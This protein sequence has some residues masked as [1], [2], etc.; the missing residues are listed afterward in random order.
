MK[1]CKFLFVLILLFEFV[2]YPILLVIHWWKVYHFTEGKGRTRNKF[3]V[4]RKV[5]VCVHEWGGYSPVR[6][7]TIKK[8]MT[9]TCGL[10]S[11]IDRFSDST[12]FDLWITMSDIEKWKY[13]YLLEKLKVYSVSNVGMDFSGYN[14][15]YQNNKEKLDSYVILTNSSVNSYNEEFIA[16]Y[17][18]YMENNLDVGALEISYCTKMYQTLVRPNF[19]PHIQSFFILTT[20]CV[21]KEIVNLNHGHF[22]GDGV[23]DKLLL[24]RRGEIKFSQL[25]LKAGY[26]LAVVDPMTKKPFKFTSFTNWIWCKGDVRQY[27]TQPN[28]I[29]SIT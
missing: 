3:D 22:P 24:I 2:F 6:T 18:N 16:S 29:I 8:G 12:R 27:V 25:I 1:R 7:K 23:G 5:K 13:P 10:Q 4:N 15:F 26:R 19:Y 14:F 28:R 17:I 11:Q 9:F 20:M 21:L